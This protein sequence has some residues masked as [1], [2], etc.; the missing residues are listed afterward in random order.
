MTSW[1]NFRLISNVDQ[2]ESVESSRT[3][4]DTMDLSKSEDFGDV[5][6]ASESISTVSPNKITPTTSATTDNV[7][8]FF[9][10]ESG[11]DAGTYLITGVDTADYLVEASGQASP[12]FSGSTGINGTIYDYPNLEDDLN[13]SRTDRKLIK[14]TTNHDDAVPTYD[15]PSDTNNKISSN[16][17]HLSTRHA[18]SLLVKNSISDNNGG[19][20]YLL[21]T[22]NEGI[23][24]VL[25]TL[26]TTATRLTGLPTL[27][28]PGSPDATNYKLN[29]VEIC[30]MDGVTL[31]N[32]NGDE[33]WGRLIDGGGTTAGSL[34]LLGGSSTG[35]GTDV[36][37]QFFTGDKGGVGTPYT[38]TA[39]ENGKAVQLKFWEMRKRDS[40]SRDD[41]PENVGS[42]RTI[43]SGNAEHGD[44]IRDSQ[45]YSGGGDNVTSPVIT[46]SSNFY[47]FSSNNSNGV[48]NPADTNLTEM[49]NVL[50][51]V[52]G[53]MSFTALAQQVTGGN[54]DTLDWTEIVENMSIFTLQGG[55]IKV[56]RFRNSV[57]L[58]AESIITIPG[59]ISYKPN[60]DTEASGLAGQYLKWE[61]GPLNL[62]PDAS[63]VLHDYAE[64][65]GGVEGVSGGQ[66]K[67][68]RFI[69]K[70]QLHT[71]TIF[72]ANN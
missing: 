8:K 60:V 41:T 51:N 40:L 58:P 65:S 18:G 67:A 63:D 9:V 69:R 43:H 11:A 13:Y 37:V 59:N 53:N 15:D 22:G 25:S 35:E 44:D 16:L 31:S 29:L 54:G 14:G 24:V 62:H 10:V 66:V 61:T 49:A 12:A 55:A 3:Y 45:E 20:G 34:T 42:G 70:N 50:N 6:V 4:K 5:R 7:G 33:I 57:P 19:G 1:E 28:G 64:V 56:V 30:D 23:R 21:A 71:F 68:H 27:D 39:S 2:K 17:L 36:V 46:N 52:N 38:M 72:R 26:Y 48:A 32:Q 47:P